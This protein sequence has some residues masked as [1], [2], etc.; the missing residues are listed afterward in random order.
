MAKCIARFSHMEV[1]DF[2][3][4]CDV[5]RRPELYSAGTKEE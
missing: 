1:T 4:E 2:K 5:T 3:T